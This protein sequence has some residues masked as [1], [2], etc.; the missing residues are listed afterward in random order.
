ASSDVVEQL[1]DLVLDAPVGRVVGGDWLVPLAPTEHRTIV[2]VDIADFSNNQ[3][4]AIHQS[5]VREGLYD[6]VKRAFTGVGL[7]YDKCEHEDRGDGML[8]LVPAE[9]PK[10]ELADKL[11][12]RLVTEIRRFNSTRVPEARMKLRVAVHAGDIRKDDHGWI[13]LPVILAFRILDAQDAKVA[14]RRSDGLLALIASD[15]FYTEVILQD[16]GTAPESYRQI[17]VMIK[18]FKGHAW[19]CMHGENSAPGPLPLTAE[20]G[21]PVVL[22]LTPA[23]E[24]DELESRLFKIDLPNLSMLVSQ[25]TGSAVSAQAFSSVW[26]AYL[27]LTDFN[28]G[29]DGVPPAVKFVEV[30][31]QKVG[32]ETG[33]HLKEWVNRS[34][35]K[36]RRAPALE[37]QRETRLSALVEPRLHLMFAIDLDSIDS[38]RCI[39]SFWRQDNPLDWPPQRGAVHELSIADLEYQVDEVIVQAEGAWSDQSA[40]VTLE[41]SLSRQLLQL[42]IYSWSKE[43]SSGHPRPLALDYSLI[44]RSLERMNTKHWYRSWRVRWDSMLENPAAERIHPLG[45]PQTGE[46]PI[47]AVL[48]DSRWIGLVMDEPPSVRPESRAAPEPLTAALRAGLPLVL[49]HPSAAPEDVRALVDRLAGGPGGVLDLPEQRRVA[50]LSADADDLVRDLVV[51]WDDP[52]RIFLSSNPAAAAVKGQ[53]G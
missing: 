18:S 40:A 8:I 16:P 44:I 26:D 19:L 25:A 17:E 13:G 39:L 7:D 32:G 46:N 5:A 42:P 28:A 38:D 12:E 22:P 47:D 37:K 1:D 41:F 14:L 20:P 3:R 49:W 34:V 53:D 23:E 30:V 9:F 15:H 50:H 36:L 21:E 10:S 6:V 4:M 43:H 27:H 48:S 11:P 52:N 2:I 29:P 51:L 31:A 45:A 24:L 33:A 35:R